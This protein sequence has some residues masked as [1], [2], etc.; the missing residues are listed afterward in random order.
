MKHLQLAILT[1]LALGMIVFSLIMNYQT[2][3]PGA[4]VDRYDEAI[5]LHEMINHGDSTVTLIM[6]GTAF[7]GIT[8][9]EINSYLNT[10]EGLGI[11]P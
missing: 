5:G 8:Y 4:F 1:I 2:S 7:D 11:K 6:E 3:R 10:G 9:D